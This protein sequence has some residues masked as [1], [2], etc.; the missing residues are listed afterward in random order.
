M[1]P[2]YGQWSETGQPYIPG[3]YHC[4]CEQWNGHTG[5]MA[6]KQPYFN[7]WQQ[8]RMVFDKTEATMI[9]Q[10]HYVSFR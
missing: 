9:H 6:I 7:L 1:K 8:E 4:L 3:F 2:V 10:G 5:C